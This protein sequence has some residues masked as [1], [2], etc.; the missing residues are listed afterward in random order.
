MNEE[1]LIERARE[2]ALKAYAPYSRFPV[3]AA[4]ECEDGSVFGGCNV[5][6]AAFGSTIC[7]ERAAVLGA[8]SAGQ[9]RFR[10]LAIAGSSGD[11]CWPCGACRQVLFEFAPEADVYLVN[12][13][14]AVVKTSVKGLLPGAFGPEK[15]PS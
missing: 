9:R 7:A 3:G 1:Q 14:G 8:V 2:A 5:E 4:L 13:L 6:N 15:L 11:Y 10:R 12:H